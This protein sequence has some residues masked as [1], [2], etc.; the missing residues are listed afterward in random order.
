MNRSKSAG[1]SLQRRIPSTAVVSGS[2]NPQ[3]ERHSL[4]PLLVSLIY[5]PLWQVSRTKRPF[6]GLVFTA[7]R[8][9]KSLCQVTTATTLV[10]PSCPV[11]Q[12]PRCRAPSLPRRDLPYAK[13]PFRSR[14]LPPCRSPSQRPEDILSIPHNLPSPP[15]AYSICLF[16]RVHHC[17]GHGSTA[18][19]LFRF[20]LKRGLHPRLRSTSLPPSVADFP[21][22]SSP[23]T[24]RFPTFQ[25]QTFSASFPF[26]PFSRTCRCI[27]AV[28]SSPNFTQ[29]YRNPRVASEKKGPVHH[30]LIVE[31]P[32]WSTL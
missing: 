3:T 23:S 11:H 24:D 14:L 17:R 6:C 18:H 30:F 4:T 12:I 5:D 15:H 22:I 26:F 13:A 20:A 16:P 8:K 1:S 28:G 31:S 27:A 29:A 9:S 32:E 7:L 10:H 19:V 2:A 21:S 25:I